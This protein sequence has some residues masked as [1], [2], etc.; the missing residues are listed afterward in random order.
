MQ[1]DCIALWGPLINGV[2][3]LIRIEI[4]ELRKRS[5][6]NKLVVILT[7][8]GGYAEVVQRIAETLRHHYMTVEFI[9]PNY[10]Y[11]AGTILVM[12]GDA[13]HMDYYSRLGP[14]DPQ[15]PTKD[16]KQV[17]ALG[18]LEK[19]KEL[20]DKS[21]SPDGLSLA[22]I[23][24]LVDGFNQAELYQYEQA[25]DLSVAL[26]R[27]WLV[28]YKFKDWNKTE[29]HQTPVTQEMKKQRAEE[30]A[31]ELNNTKRWHTHGRGISRDVLE[32]D[33]KLKIDDLDAPAAT[34]LNKKIKEYY[35]LLADYMAKR[36]TS[37]V[38]HSRGAW[39]PFF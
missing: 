7:S 23:Q 8:G 13:I 6:K 38:V 15:V 5:K 22:E 26:L 10:A 4:E 14:I 29:G 36:S 3:D 28:K 34:S 32:K 9:V 30:I 21:K 33:L 11:S 31:N 17:P 16:G 39:K 12:S 20:I 35:D 37:G 27:E 1:A 25:R 19:Y 18:Y 2:D 24:L